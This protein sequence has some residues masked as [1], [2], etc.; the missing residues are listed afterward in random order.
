[1]SED[2]HDSDNRPA[3]R[4]NPAPAHTCNIH[5]NQ[6]CEACM[7]FAPL[8]KQAAPYQVEGTVAERREGPQPRH[9]YDMHTCKTSRLPCKQCEYWTFSRHDGATDLRHR[10]PQNMAYNVLIMQSNAAALAG[11]T[12]KEAR[13][14]AKAY[15]MWY[16]DSE[17]L[18][19][20]IT[21]LDSKWME[22]L[23]IAPW[24]G[25]IPA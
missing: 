4:L 5:P 8:R 23:H 14:K 16:A 25:E 3:R 1:M 7:I 12:E 11:D 21:D 20:E 18:A 24:N 6:P 9:G 13:L 15:A 2:C 19:L 22:Q 17:L 10:G